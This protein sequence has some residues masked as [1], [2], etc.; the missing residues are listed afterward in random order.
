MWCCIMKNIRREN[1]G[2]LLNS[3]VVSNFIALANNIPAIASAQGVPPE[4]GKVYVNRDG[5]K[6]IYLGPG[7]LKNADQEDITNIPIPR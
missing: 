6:F 5:G 2:S 1:V 7:V 3:D 4:F